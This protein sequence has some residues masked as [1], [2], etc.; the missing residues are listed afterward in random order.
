MI[1]DLAVRSNCQYIV[2]YN[3]S[4]FYGVNQFGIQVVTA[5]EFLQAIEVI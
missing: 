5:Q 4:D 2:T 1:P 3:T